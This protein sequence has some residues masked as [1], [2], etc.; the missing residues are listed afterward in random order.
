MAAQALGRE[1]TAE[2]CMNTIK[3]IISQDIQKLLDESDPRYTD[4]IKAEQN[5]QKFGLDNFYEPIE[6]KEHDK[7]VREAENL[8]KDDNVSTALI[9]LALQNV[10]QFASDET[11]LITR[12]EERKDAT[13][14]IDVDRVLNDPYATAADIVRALAKN[15][16][17]NNANKDQVHDQLQNKLNNRVRDEAVNAMGDPNTTMAD[18]L[19]LASQAEACG[20]T[21]L[22]ELMKKKAAD[23]PGRP[24]VSVDTPTPPE[25][26]DIPYT[27]PNAFNEEAVALEALGLKSFDEE[28]FT[29][30]AN[31]FQAKAQDAS[32]MA[33]AECAAQG[34]GLLCEVAKGLILWL[35]QAIHDGATEFGQ[36]VGEVQARPEDQPVPYDGTNDHDRITGN[37]IGKE[38][39]GSMQPYEADLYTLCPGVTRA[40]F[41]TKQQEED[42]LQNEFWDADHFDKAKCIQAFPAA[43]YAGYCDWMEG[44]W[45]ARQEE[46][47]NPDTAAS[48]EDS[49]DDGLLDQADTSGGDQTPSGNGQSDDAPAAEPVDNGSSVNNDGTSAY[50]Q[51]L[52][53]EEMN[54]I[55]EAR[56]ADYHLCD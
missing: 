50:D 22:S 11:G 4:L 55:Q 7:A 51:C 10:L 30:W 12:L 31:D 2:S 42:R 9:M 18:Y 45:N 17:T 54:E 14:G 47:N 52:T 38:E 15:D 37:C 23:A 43:T 16:V 40:D 39:A 49:S 29:E 46:I 5:A 53:Q 13:I 8:L 24:P 21:D 56:R 25:N 3:N 1:D 44:M 26:E 36:E 34:G 35:G 20:L 27:D 48:S 33:G 19:A 28:G 6:K 32:T 41:G